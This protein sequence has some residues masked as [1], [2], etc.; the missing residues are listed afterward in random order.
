MRSSAAQRVTE[1]ETRMLVDQDD[2]DPNA[3]LDPELAKVI[4]KGIAYFDAG[5]EGISHEAAM[6]R[7]RAVRAG[8]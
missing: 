4:D 8:G 5:G 2:V 3:P 1:D 6:Q 7:L